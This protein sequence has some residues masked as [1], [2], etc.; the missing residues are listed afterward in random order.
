MIVLKTFCDGSVAAMSVFMRGVRPLGWLWFSEGLRGTCT[1]GGPELDRPPVQP[2]YVLPTIRTFTVGPGFPPGQPAAG[3]GRVADCHR[4]LGVSPTPEHV[5]G[6][7]PHAA[8][9][10]Q[11]APP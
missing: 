8:V 7:M 3:C 9:W 10:R 5:G 4:R 6:S 11:G 1:T 2:S